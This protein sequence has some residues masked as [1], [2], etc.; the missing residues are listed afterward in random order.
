MTDEE[1]IVALRKEQNRLLKEAGELAKTNQ[2]KSDEDK[3]KAAKIE[4]EIE[5]IQDKKGKQ[6][7]Y[8]DDIRRR[9]GIGVNT[10]AVLAGPADHTVQ[11]TQATKDST[12]ATQD[13][14]KA[15]K[16]NTKAVQTKSGA[17]FS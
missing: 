17:T 1:K 11:L 9:G 15:I 13:N 16:D 5:A 7:I 3:I 2:K 12:K 8:T 4:G 6:T 14:T 10:R